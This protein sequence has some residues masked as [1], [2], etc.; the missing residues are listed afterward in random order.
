MDVLDSCQRAFDSAQDVMKSV[1]PEDLS[2]PSPC[3]DWDVRALTNHMVSTVVAFTA[4]ARGSENRSTP[5]HRKT[6][7]VMIRVPLSPPPLPSLWTPG[8][9]MVI[10]IR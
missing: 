1:E 5:A 10:S 9:A 4:A 7:W 2:K 3:S 6:S 8:A